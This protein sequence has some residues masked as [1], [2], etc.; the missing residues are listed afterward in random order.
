MLATEVVGIWHKEI[1][2]LQAAIVMFDA[3]TD[4][5]LVA[6]RITERL[7]RTPFHLTARPVDPP[8]GGGFGIRCRSFNRN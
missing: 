6:H 2:V 7:A 4:R 3:A 5:D 1:C 8:T